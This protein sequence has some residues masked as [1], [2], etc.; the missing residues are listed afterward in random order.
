MM[1]TSKLIFYN[2][3]PA[4]KL[5]SANVGKVSRCSI[6]YGRCQVLLRLL[7]WR[8]CRAWYS[9]SN[10]DYNV[11]RAQRGIVYID[12]IDKISRKSDNPSITRDVSGEES[13]RHF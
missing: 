7:C 5:L 2:V 10:Y 8:R 6:Y 12:E 1:L 9:T 11:E 3:Q 4:G 13:N